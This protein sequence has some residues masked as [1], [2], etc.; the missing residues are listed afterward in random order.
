MPDLVIFQRTAKRVWSALQALD[1]PFLWVEPH[2][3]TLVDVHYSICWIR[4]AAKEWEHSVKKARIQNWKDKIQASAT[5]NFKYVYQ[6]LK[7]KSLE[8]PINLVLN[9]QGHIVYNPPEAI[10]CIVNTWDS[11]FSAN[12]LHHDPVQMLRDHSIATFQLPPL[13]G[14]DIYQTIQN[15]RADAAPGMDGWRTSDLQ[16]LPVK[17]CSII[18]DFFSALE[19][20]CQFSIPDVLVRAKQVI[21]NKPGPSTPLNK[22]LITVLPPL[23]LAYT[24]TR[25]RQL[26]SWQSTILP[27]QLCGGI[28]QR[29]MTD[30]SVGLRLDIDQSYAQDEPLIGIK[31]DQSKCFDRL[32]PQFTAALFLAMGLP[33]GIVNLFVKI[34]DGLKKHV[35]YRGWVSSTPIT[36]ANGL[37]QGCSFSLLAINVHMAVWTRFMDLLPHVTCRAFIDDSY[38]WVRLIHASQLRTAFDVTQQWSKLIGQ[39]LNAAKSSLW[40]TNTEA[41][42]V[43]K[44]LFPEIPL[45]LEMDVLG[46]KMYT[47]QRKC[48]LFPESKTEKICNDVKNIAALPLSCKNKAHLIASKVIPQCSFA[49]EISDMP[50]S[51]LNKVQ[52]VIATALWHNRPHWRSKMFVFC[53]LAQPWRVEPTIA[54]AYCAVRNM[55]RYVHS[56]PCCLERLRNFFEAMIKCKHSLLAHFRQALQVFHLALFS[57]MSIRIGTVTFSILDIHPKDLRPFLHTMAQQACYEASGTK[58]RK[59][60]YK[61]TGL[62]DGYLSTAFHRFHAKK[63]DPC[64]FLKPHFDSQLVGCTITN[65]R[66]FAA[67]FSETSDCRFCGL[68]KESLTHIVS[69]CLACP[70]E[71]QACIAHD[72]GPNY[73]NLG[74]FE[75]PVA[76][77]DK[78]LAMSRWDPQS[79]CSFDPRQPQVLRWTDGSVVMQKSFWLSAAGYSVVDE[80]MQC[81]EAGPVLHLLLASYTAELY[82]ILRAVASTSAPVKIFTDSLTI[83]DMFA[84]LE[85]TGQV[86]EDWSL[87]EWWKILARLWRT[88]KAFHPKPVTLVWQKAHTCDH[89][90]TQEISEEIAHRFGLTRQQVLCNRVADCAAKKAAFDHA[91]IDPCHFP[92]IER[93]VCKRQVE[94]A[95]LNHVIGSNCQVRQQFMTKEDDANESGPPDYRLRFPLWEW[96]ASPASY[97]KSFQGSVP[98]PQ[99]LKSAFSEVDV[100]TV[101]DFLQVLKWRVADDQ[102]VSYVELTLLFIRKGFVLESIQHADASFRDVMQVV[103]RVCART[104]LCDTQDRLPG[105]HESTLIHKC[106]KAIPKGAIFGARPFFDPKDLVAFAAILQDGCGQHLSSWSF[107]WHVALSN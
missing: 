36:C 96:N 70:P 39:Q 100:V 2:C 26:Q 94:L 15:R 23:L 65:D 63:D 3:P 6:H 58:P 41:R 87:L 4:N 75:H 29:S 21:L 99:E 76:I 25:F 54:R 64:A 47:A 13:T 35:A 89:L 1:A 86:S 73:R 57:D 17:C 82:A 103:K 32:I 27:R 33:K 31:L 97:D 107:D 30:I 8:E 5:G 88:R 79:E 81:L 20:D 84:Q 50:K 101:Y 85:L 55:W 66:R 42:R 10:E 49:S 59:D 12:V 68:V 92:A 106:G 60:I 22:R 44:S 56:H 104:F 95:K 7:N 38:L 91:A 53:F 16:S 51:A 77:A 62:L 74:I 11:V 40:A 83:V 34:Y 43:A 102:S 48:T 90:E 67:G 93:I 28:P 98:L 105:R 72:F 37:A 14:L 18:A 19:D 80:H 9:S 52:G 69:E 71:L 45:V 46:T 61:P 24:G 78:R